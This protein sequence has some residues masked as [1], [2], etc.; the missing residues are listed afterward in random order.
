VRHLR[1]SFRLVLALALAWPAT[2]CSAGPK[3]EGATRTAA[4]VAGLP[5]AAAFSPELAERLTAGLASKGWDYEPRTHHRHADGSR[6]DAEPFLDVLRCTYLPNKVRVVVVESGPDPELH[7]GRVPLIRGKVARKGRA[8][9]YVCKRGVCQL[10][11][12]EVRVFARQPEPDRSATPA[13][14]KSD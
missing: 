11:T 3:A 2:A 13:P 1:P 14:G 8:T 6:Q 4:T 5:G 10:P 9:A 7:A 12:T